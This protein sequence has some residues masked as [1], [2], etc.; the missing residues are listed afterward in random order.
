VFKDDYQIQKFTVERKAQVKGGCC[1][2]NIQAV[3]V[4]AAES[5]GDR[6]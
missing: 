6:R 5:K 3:A 4:C 2:V 1:I